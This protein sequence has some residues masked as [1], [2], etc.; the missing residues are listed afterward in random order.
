MLTS[1]EK[2]NEIVNKKQ[3]QTMDRSREDLSLAKG[4][5][6]RQSSIPHKSPVESNTSSIHTNVSIF[7]WK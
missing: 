1:M 7:Q 3:G 4:P 6:S 2:V 5:A